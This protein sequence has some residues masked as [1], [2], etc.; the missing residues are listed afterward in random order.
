MQRMKLRNPSRRSGRNRNSGPGAAFTLIELLVV[1]AIIAILAAMLLPA[2]AK[3]KARAH[4]ANCV[5]NLK[6]IGIAL[7]LYADDHEQ[8]WPYPSVDVHVLYPDFTGTATKA[9]WTKTLGM[10]KY[11][12]QRN[13]LLSDIG[14]PVN[15]VFNCPSANY[16][17]NGVKLAPTD[18]SGTY[19]CA[20]TMFGRDSKGK[21]TTSLPRK[22]TQGQSPSDTFLVIEGLREHKNDSSG[23]WSIDCATSMDWDPYGKAIPAANSPKDLDFPPNINTSNPD[24][25]RHGA[26]DTMNVTWADYSVHSIKFAYAKNWV[27]QERWDAP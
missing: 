7:S 1:I 6:Q 14:S 21:T 15:R 8:F 10:G 22:V 27:N 9:I 4:N 2:L 5:S 18:L 13:G 19:A 24:F 26:A 3:A 25:L 20:G 17:T 23:S 16:V 12:P 11:L